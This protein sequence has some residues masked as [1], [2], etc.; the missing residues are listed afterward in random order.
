MPT[1]W[2]KR[3]KTEKYDMYLGEW[4]ATSRPLR[5]AQRHLRRRR[6]ADHWNDQKYLD[7]IKAANVEP[8]RREAQ[9]DVRG[10]GEVHDPGSDG[11]DSAVRRRS[12][13]GRAAVGRRGC[14]VSPFDCLSISSSDATIDQ[15]LDCAYPEPSP[16]GNSTMRAYLARR[17]AE[18]HPVDALSYTLVFMLIHLTPGNPWDN[19]DKPFAPEV[20][21]SLE[22]NIT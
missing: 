14:K 8:D 19:I 21:Q 16:E 6:L 7:M 20:L 2:R 12:A 15:A 1:D 22:Q 4:R 10:G 9:A 13:L 18:L 11:D 3:I 5:V 17:T